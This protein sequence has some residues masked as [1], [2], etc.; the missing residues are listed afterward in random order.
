MYF[1][2]TKPSA[3]STELAVQIMNVEEAPKNE[4]I[5]TVGEKNLTN[6]SQVLSQEKYTRN[7]DLNDTDAPILGDEAELKEQIRVLRAQNRLLYDDNVDLVDK[8]LEILNLLSSQKAEL[9]TRRK[10]AASA[11]D[12]QRL[13]MIDEL[14]KKLAKAQEEN[15][16]NKNLEQN[17]TSLREEIKSLKSELEKKR[18]SKYAKTARG[19]K[20]RVEERSTN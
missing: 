2:F 16:K 17:L 13:S 3:K 15:E 14:N 11:N 4:S 6:Q 7:V 20:R 5:S 12:K 18:K 9:E 8:N 10:Q 19:S 1:E